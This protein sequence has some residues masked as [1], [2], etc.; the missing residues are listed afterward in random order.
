MLPALDTQLYMQEKPKYE[1]L[2]VLATTS[3]VSLDAT[4]GQIRVE[5]YDSVGLEQLREEQRAEMSGIM[6]LNYRML[7]NLNEKM[8]L[9]YQR[10][11]AKK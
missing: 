1:Q 4:T 5:R 11:M 2:E 6:E 3:E 9:A 8:K 10:K 7:N